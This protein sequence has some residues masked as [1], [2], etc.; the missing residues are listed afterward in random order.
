MAKR[1]IVD[2]HH[3]LWQLSDGYKY[4]WLQDK[5][6]GEGMLGSLASIAVDYL[7]AGYRSDTANYDVVKTVHIEAVPSVAVAETEWLQRIADREGFPHAIVARVELAMPDAERVMATHKAFRNV[8]GIRQIA[9]WHKDGR[10]TFTDRDYLTDAAWVAG[11]RLLKK[12]DLSFD[13][14]IYPGQMIAAAALAHANPDTAMI[15]N[16]TGMPLERDEA[17]LAAWRTGMRA[18]AAEPNVFAKI[19]G[20]GMV[21][22]KW[23]EA[24][25]RPFVLGTI[26]YFGTDRAMFG[27]N[28]PVDR[29]Y[30]SFDALYGAFESIVAS[31]SESEKAKLF[32]DNAL[33]VY[34]I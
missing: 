34:R 20:M 5:S 4:P 10:Y 16:H 24:S 19:S 17:G 3:H 33:R 26:D 2:A 13:L 9:N 21:E 32:H 1:K 12:Y 18:L 22:H 14:Q 27:S 15:L 6:S 31:F 8:R 28:F 11:Y 25:I 7:P 30:S 29:L 23:S